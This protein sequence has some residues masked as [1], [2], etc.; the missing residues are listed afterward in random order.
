MTN[1]DRS[2]AFYNICCTLTHNLLAI[3]LIS[4]HSY[5]PGN[6]YL[7]GKKCAIPSLYRDFYVAKDEGP[8]P[9]L[10][11]VTPTNFIAGPL[12]AI[13]RNPGDKQS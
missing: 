1:P 5:T 12:Y 13:Y 2:T 11:Q 10:R 6:L 8:C 7:D 3:K 9:V 4:R